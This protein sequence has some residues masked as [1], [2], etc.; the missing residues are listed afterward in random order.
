MCGFGSL[1]VS[2]VEFQ[3]S[4]VEEFCKAFF[5]LVSFGNREAGLSEGNR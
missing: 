2:E 3:M 5:F 4:E 1:T